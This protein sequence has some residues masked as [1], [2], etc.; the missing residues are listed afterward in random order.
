MNAALPAVTCSRRR[1]VVPPARVQAR[2]EINL[3]ALLCKDS[4]CRGRGPRGRG[5]AEHLPE[6]RAQAAGG[7]RPGPRGCQCPPG[8]PGPGPA[9]SGCPTG[10]LGGCPEIALSGPDPLAA[11]PAR[12]QSR[13]DCHAPSHWHS[14]SAS[15]TREEAVTVL[16]RLSSIRVWGL[17]F[18]ASM[19]QFNIGVEP[20][21]FNSAVGHFV[22]TAY[23]KTRSWWR[24]TLH[25]QTC[26]GT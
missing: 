2:A 26:L 14:A 18:G 23:K 7:M 25:E 15:G 16:S 4:L 17:A 13:R 5:A 10:K 24:D 11:G 21:H 6:S 12:G 19:F 8:R 1:A 3:K 20:R 22:R 9:A